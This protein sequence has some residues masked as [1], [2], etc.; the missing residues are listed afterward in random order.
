[1]NRESPV[2]EPYLARQLIP[3]LGNKRALLRHMKPVFESINAGRKGALFLDPF[4]GSGSV[5]RLARSL[6]MA[7][8]ANDWEPY[9]E[10]INRCW[11]E[12]TPADLG[13]AFTDRGGVQAFLTGWNRMHPLDTSADQGAPGN[14]AERRYMARWYAPASTEHPDLDA[15]RLFYSAENALFLDRVRFRLEDE[16]AAVDPGSTEDI[17]RRVILGGLLLEAATHANTS[18]VFKAYHRG[19]G[20]HGGD[21][22]HRI[23]ARMELEV[24]HLVDAPP[25]I[26]HSEDASCFCARYSADLV[27]IDPPYNQHQYGANY[28]ILNTIVRW[29]G[30]PEPLDRGSDGR[31][32]RKAGIPEA[33]AL[34]RSPYCSRTGSASALAKLFNA[35]DSA[36][37][38]VSWNGDAH[39]TADELAELLSARGELRIEHLDHAVYR[40]GRQSASRVDRSS[41]YL[42]IVDCRKASLSPCQALARLARGQAL[43]QAMR[44]SY[45]PSRLR[46][47]FMTS[48][49]GLLLELAG[50]PGPEELL[51]P[52]VTLVPMRHL[53]KFEPDARALLGLLPEEKVTG[54]LA[55]L[56]AC[57]CSGVVDE[58]DAIAEVAGEGHPGRPK[59]SLVARR[60]APRLIRKLAHR[61][62][63]EAFRASLQ[64]FRAIAHATNDQVLRKALDSL[65][66]IATARFSFDPKTDPE[67]KAAS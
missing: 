27:Y 12:L 39:L 62:Y 54:I 6:G 16:Y 7:V 32:L 25:A 43:E 33:A 38:V 66:M 46:R 2:D 8:R 56:G 36:A 61:K 58:L 14:Q 9:S 65:E 13:S 42:F 4:A 18:G 67:E 57:A 34:T 17:R 10:S 23:L 3:Y 30:R 49:D 47:S 19:F 26:I 29:D 22:L 1:M 24:P 48:E 64:R 28:H 41:E 40:G 20:G 44:A 35:I 37:I 11:L 31:L 15:E 55:G 59:A 51:A 21:A 5:S 63:L 60:E 45:H 52:A 50:D 53:R